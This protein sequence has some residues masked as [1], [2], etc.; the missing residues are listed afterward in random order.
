MKE[1]NSTLYTHTHTH[2][3]L[4]HF[5]QNKFPIFS[6]HF[7]IQQLNAEGL[8]SGVEG[9]KAFVKV[10]IRKGPG[11]KGKGKCRAVVVRHHQDL[12]PS[13]HYLC[14]FLTFLSP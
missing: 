14:F 2:S 5:T 6:S 3:S 12:Y 7:F 9:A 10:S 4:T 8:A 11:R 13:L 1:R